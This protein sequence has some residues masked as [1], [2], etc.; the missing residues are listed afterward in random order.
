MGKNMSTPSGGDIM[1]KHNG[2]TALEWSVID[3]GA[4]DGVGGLNLFLVVNT[5]CGGTLL[6]ICRLSNHGLYL[7]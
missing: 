5:T 2:S 7:Y 4:G 1:R 6:A 3:Y